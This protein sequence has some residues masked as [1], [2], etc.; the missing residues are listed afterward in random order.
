[1]LQT[2]LFYFLEASVSV[3]FPMNG[4]VLLGLGFWR[5]DV[6]LCSLQSCKF[7]LKGRCA[8]FSVR[9]FWMVEYVHLLHVC[10]EFHFALSE[11]KSLLTLLLLGPDEKSSSPLWK[12]RL[13]RM[14]R[15]G[16]GDS[17]CIGERRRWKKA[18][19]LGRVS[20]SSIAWKNLGR[21]WARADIR[22]AW[23]WVESACLGSSVPLSSHC[24]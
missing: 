12:R 7:S 21:L 3:H 16:A 2:S 10:L 23:P 9:S 15:R 24:K 19:Q 13:W 14:Q 8:V 6:I 22:G 1:M 11:M 17:A 18:D 5:N 4:K 20:M